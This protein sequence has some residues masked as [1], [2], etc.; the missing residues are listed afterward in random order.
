M[1]RH[2]HRDPENLP[3]TKSRLSD[4]L[5]GGIRENGD[6]TLSVKQRPNH[7]NPGY[8]LMRRSDEKVDIPHTRPPVFP[9]QSRR[10]KE[11]SK[12]SNHKASS[13]AVVVFFMLS[14]RRPKCLQGCG[15]FSSSM[16][17]KP[18]H[19]GWKKK[20]RR[21][22]SKLVSEAEKGVVMREASC[23]SHWEK[24]ESNYKTVGDPKYFAIALEH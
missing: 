8:I 3:E 11:Q 5:R 21:R 18:E 24:K 1:H 4:W 17:S 16:S 20:E 15:E 7:G 13:R 9:D 2:R 23:S 22:L 19:S 6:T 14:E 12:L 10:K